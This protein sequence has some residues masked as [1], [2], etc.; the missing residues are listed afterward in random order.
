MELQDASYQQ[1]LLVEEGTQSHD[2]NK[3][4][5]LDD[6]ETTTTCSWQYIRDE[7]W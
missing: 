6:N 3:E 1:S 2:T 5:K 7:V 4:A